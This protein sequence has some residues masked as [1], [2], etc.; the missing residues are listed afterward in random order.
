MGLSRPKRKNCI[1]KTMS[2]G[3]SIRPALIRVFLYG[4]NVGSDLIYFYHFSP[5]LLATHSYASPAATSPPLSRI[6]SPV[7]LDEQHTRPP[8]QP[9]PLRHR[10]SNAEVSQDPERQVAQRSRW[11]A[12]L[13]EA[14]GLGVALSDENMRRLKYCLNWLQVGIRLRVSFC[15]SS[16]YVV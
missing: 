12:M 14:G 6:G 3:S 8:S 15:R 7:P 2:R 13:L 5:P 11:Q 16:S 10:H 1:Q 4:S 9:A